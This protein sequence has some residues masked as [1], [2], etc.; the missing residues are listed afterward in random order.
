MTGRIIVVGDI[1]TDVLAVYNGQLVTD[2]DTPARVALTAGGSAANT[3][4]WLAAAGTPVTMVGVVGDDAAGDARLG[5]L[6]AAGVDAVVRQVADAATGTVVVLSRADER[7]MLCDRGANARLTEADIDRA[8]AA[9]GDAVHLHLSGYALFD[10][11]SRPAG[12]YALAAA[13]A[14]GLTTSVDAASAGPLRR[15]GGARFLDWVHG[16]DVL[17]ANL[18]EAVVLV[19]APDPVPLAGYARHAVVKRGADGASWAT[20]GSSPV[21]V[22]AQPARAVDVTGAGD[23]FAAGL[24]RAWLA[25]APPVD[26]LREGARLGA[27]AV[28]VAGARPPATRA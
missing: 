22:P 8:L 17:L 26:A 4:T 25:G 18:D 14:A 23:A 24:L 13:R 11:E 7:T 27:A 12:R 6:T 3:A 10:G 19:G 1:V 15:V 21:D 2:S 9:A 16:T 20:S 28:S 5:E